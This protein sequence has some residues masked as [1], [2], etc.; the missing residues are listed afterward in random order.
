MNYRDNFLKAAR[1]IGRRLN[2]VFPN[3]TIVDKDTVLDEDH[4]VV[5][6][7]VQSTPEIEEL[8][9]DAEAAKAVIENVDRAAKYLK[10]D[11]DHYAYPEEQRRELVEKYRE[12]KK[13]GR[14]TNKK[15]WIEHKAMVNVR[16][17]LNWEKEF[18][19]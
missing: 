10:R 15:T 11:S 5:G 14:I 16:T 1:K 17:F 3:P 19:E 8:I 6:S 12:A 7:F 18:P 13:A 9:N 4:S 2:K